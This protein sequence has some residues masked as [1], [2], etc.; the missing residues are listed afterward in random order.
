MSRI[1]QLPKDTQENLLMSRRGDYLATALFW[2]VLDSVVIDLYVS[3]VTQVGEVVLGCA[4]RSAFDLS[5]REP[6]GV[7]SFFV[8]GALDVC[9]TTGPYAEQGITLH[10]IMAPEDRAQV[11]TAQLQGH[12]LAQSFP[13]ASSSVERTAAIYNFAQNF[14]PS[15]INEFIAAYEETSVSAMKSRLNRARAA[16][17][18]SRRDGNVRT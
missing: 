2:T 8:E 18:L 4:V 13:M 10:R 14:M 12:D 5:G 6:Q 9:Q 11:L 17:L 16:G 7:A 1:K 15:T 3:G